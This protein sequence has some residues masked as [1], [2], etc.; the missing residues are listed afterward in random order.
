M[1][2]KGVLMKKILIAIVVG[3]AALGVF[4][5]VAYFVF[6]PESKKIQGKMERLVK[7][8]DETWFMSDPVYQ[9][10]VESEMDSLQLSLAHAYVNEG[11][12]DGA[13]S[14]AEQLIRDIQKEEVIL[15]QAVPRASAS[16]TMEGIYY[17]VLAKAYERKADEPSAQKAVKKKEMLNAKAES[18]HKAERAKAEKERSRLLE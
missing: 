1:V 12:P 9:I 2:K 16:Y 11:N 3:A 8:I 13:I 15:G 17:D 7:S 18:L 4:I 5:A 6:T 10:E 14:T